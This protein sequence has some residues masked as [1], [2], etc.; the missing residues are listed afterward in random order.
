MNTHAKN[1]FKF[2]V[3]VPILMLATVA[4]YVVAFFIEILCFDERTIWKD[5]WDVT[6][7]LWKK[8]VS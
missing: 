6:R 3:G 4:L 2:T 7:S 5:T 8:H 1:F